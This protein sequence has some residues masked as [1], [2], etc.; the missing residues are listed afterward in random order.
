MNRAAARGLG[1]ILLVCAGASVASAQN[2]SFD[3]R[4]IGMGGVGGSGNLATKMID[5]QRDYSS[6][7]IP[8][9]LIQVLGNTDVFDPGK[10]TFDPILAVEYAA[11]PF[12]FV[13]GRDPS[14][15]AAEVAFIHDARNAT[16]NRNLAVYK[17]FVPANELLAEGLVS[18]NFG[19]TFKF[20]KQDGGTFHGIY[21]GVGPW[22]S[23]HTLTTISDDLTTVLR[24]GVNKPNASFPIVEGDEGQGA[25]AITGG[26]RGR[27]AWPSGVGSGSD[28]EGLYVA[29]NYNILRGF[30]Y[31]NDT[32]NVGI[33]TD[34]AGL[35]TTT[36][37]ILVTHR[38]ASSGSG[39]AIDLGVGG[40]IDRWEF[41]AGARG[42]GNKITWTDV[43]QRTFTLSSLLNGGDFVEGVTTKV[44]DAKVKLPVDYRGNVAY[45]VDGFSIAAEA[46]HGFGG[47]SFHGGVEKRLGAIDL[48]GGA[49]YTVK[50]WN[51]TVGVGL[52]LS[53]K[54]A[55][56]VAAFGTTANFERKHETAIAASIRI[57]HQ[58]E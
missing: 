33:Q 26:Y 25:F 15:N 27:F 13:I 54:V 24:T 42:I 57:N 7:V 28:R 29:A 18:P 52:N 19:H 43:E 1:A 48:R 55:I 17:G 30:G 58:R 51:P 14:N 12:H 36:S 37:N 45:N 9:G 56:D 47:S 21:V 16:L 40:V 4:T 53:R 49:R 10:D 6:I 31:T 32:M 11:S 8:I 34:A 41:G 5:E 20:H 3:A 46:G 35:V 22:L 38:D 44:G 23:M 2:W 39:M 50:K